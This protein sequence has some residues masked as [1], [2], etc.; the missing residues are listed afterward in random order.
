M[1][2][3]LDLCLIFLQQHKNICQS[4][5]KNWKISKFLFKINLYKYISFSLIIKCVNECI[6]NIVFI[7]SKKKKCKKSARWR[8]L[9]MIKSKLVHSSRLLSSNANIPKVKWWNQDWLNHTREKQNIFLIFYSCI[10][11]MNILL[12]SFNFFIPIEFLFYTSNCL[13]GN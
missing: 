12:S 11:L 10:Y 1:T 3:K 9:K 6:V 2:F 13:E 5:S 7:L 4:Y 8:K